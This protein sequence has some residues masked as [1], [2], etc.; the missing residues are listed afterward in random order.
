MISVQNFKI[1]II[2][3]KFKLYFNHFAYLLIKKFKVLFNEYFNIL[4]TIPH[5][6]LL[7]N[8]QIFIYYILNALMINSLFILFIM[9][10]INAMI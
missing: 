1:C 6:L 8:K 2:L 3:H 10:L 9:F 5:V 4:L 7:I